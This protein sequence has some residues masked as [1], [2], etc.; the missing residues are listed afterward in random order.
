MLRGVS[1]VRR[2]SASDVEDVAACLRAAFAPYRAQYTEEAYSDTVPD[3]EG[4]AARLASMAVFVAEDGDGAVV[5]TI[6][7]GSSGGGGHIRGM[8]VLPRVQGSGVAASLLA[9][10]EAAF[11]ERGC[12]TVSLDTTMPLARAIRFYERSGYRASG[13]VA[14]FF[15][16]PLYEYRKEL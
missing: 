2:A 9:A 11:R 6:G 8:A 5:G 7:A 3:L 10:A 13:K 14:D 4:V 12:S 16:M 15:G 1:V